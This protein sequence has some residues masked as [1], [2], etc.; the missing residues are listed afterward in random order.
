MYSGLRSKH[1]GTILE[2]PLGNLDT[3]ASNAEG[4]SD[5]VRTLAMHGIARDLML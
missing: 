5:V 4:K 1:I 3:V 2:H